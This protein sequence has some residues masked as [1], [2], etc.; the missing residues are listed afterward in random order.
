[1]HYHRFAHCLA[2]AALVVSWFVI[3]TS[4]GAQEAA[5]A[6]ES[7]NVQQSTAGIAEPRSLAELTKDSRAALRAEA[8]LTEPEQWE[9]AVRA[10]VAL[11]EELRVH[12]K[13]REGSS[14][15]RLKRSVRRRFLKAQKKL[16]A[17]KISWSPTNGRSSI[18]R[19]KSLVKGPRRSLSKRAAFGRSVERES[20]AGAVLAE[21]Q[22]PA[23][24]AQPGPWVITAKISSSS[25]KARSMPTFGSRLAVLRR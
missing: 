17:I 16:G 7:V 12:P 1:M 8:T 21:R 14:F 19:S 23:L 13:N 25:S 22:E 15:E 11:N 5:R 24:Q 6:Q 9:T 2:F 10:L 3:A 18:T 20:G 4:T